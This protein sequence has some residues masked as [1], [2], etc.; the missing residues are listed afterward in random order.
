MERWTTEVLRHK[1]FRDP[2][3]QASR[4][5]AGEAFFGAAAGTAANG[6]A[7]LIIVMIVLAGTITVGNVVRFA[8]AFGRFLEAAARVVHGVPKLAMAARLHRQRSPTPQHPQRVGRPGI[9]TPMLPHIDTI[10][11]PADPHRAGNRTQQITP[12]QQK[13]NR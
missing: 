13:T 5:D 12:Q 4:N 9:M 3:I 7:Y 6:G 8:G 1:G 10:K 11:P 2:M